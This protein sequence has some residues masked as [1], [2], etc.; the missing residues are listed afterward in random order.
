MI[1]LFYD[2][3][4]DLSTA[5]TTRAPSTPTITGLRDN[6]ANNSTI[7][8][9]V[10]KHNVVFHADTKD[11]GTTPIRI[12]INSQQMQNIHDAQQKQTNNST[13]FRA[14]VLP[15]GDPNYPQIPTALVV[16]PHIP[17]VH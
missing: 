3:T 2:G 5:T 4:F 16:V 6:G 14:F 11:G 7:A 8:T 10:V 17:V 1:Q 13:K 15:M 9:L 12:D